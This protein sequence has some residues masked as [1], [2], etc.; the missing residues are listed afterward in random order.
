MA[1]N[2][3]GEDSFSCS[4]RV[5]LRRCRP[6]LKNGWI[7]LQNSTLTNNNW[8]GAIG[9]IQSGGRQ[10]GAF[11]GIGGGLGSRRRGDE[12]DDWFSSE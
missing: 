11:V 6:P 7:E 3:S 12:L 2:R 1:E 10:A 4:T 8:I 9:R 5:L